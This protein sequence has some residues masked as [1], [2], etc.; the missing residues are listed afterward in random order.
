MQRSWIDASSNLAGCPS[1]AAVSRLPPKQDRVR[2]NAGSSP[3]S[4]SSL[5]LDALRFESLF[6]LGR[7]SGIE[8]RL[9]SYRKIGTGFYMR[10]PQLEEGPGPNRQVNSS[11]LFTHTGG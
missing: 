4:G 5:V 9:L 7:R 11:N 1:Y 2:G 3:A 8:V 6:H 10:V